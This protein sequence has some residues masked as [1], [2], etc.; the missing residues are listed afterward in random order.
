MI[1]SFIS[2][3]LYSFIYSISI[4]PFSHLLVRYW[5]VII[6]STTFDTS[7]IVQY[8]L[9]LNEPQKS[10]YKL[11]IQNGGKQSDNKLNITK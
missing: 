9:D 1:H 3:S 10:T 6:W 7:T 4:H 8:T 11:K 2:S 5:L